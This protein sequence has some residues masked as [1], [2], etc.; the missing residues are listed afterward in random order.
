MQHKA[1]R[2][3]REIRSVVFNSF[4]DS[5]KILQIPIPSRRFDVPPPPLPEEAGQ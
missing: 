4:I 3:I 5:A 2:R 1:G